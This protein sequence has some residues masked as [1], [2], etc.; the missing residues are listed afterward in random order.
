MSETPLALPTSIPVFS[1]AGFSNSG[2]TTLLCKIV[3]NLKARGLTVATVKHDGHDF[4]MDHEGKDTWKHRQAGSDVVAITSASKVAI[5]DYRPYEREQQ[6]IQVLSTIKGVDIIL[7]EGFK[8]VAIPKIFV[9]R[10]KEQMQE[11][12]SIPMVEGIASD[13]PLEQS[14]LQVYDINDVQAISQ[15]IVDKFSLDR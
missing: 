12:G 13:F 11:I 8:A 3:S 2:K 4:S 9:T 5:I 7:V 14:L 10:N 6:L 15:Y 1:L